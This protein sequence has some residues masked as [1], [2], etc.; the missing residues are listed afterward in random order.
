MPVP[1]TVPMPV[2]QP[3]ILVIIG[4]PLYG[5]TRQL[6]S[7]S[8]NRIGGPA[9]VIGLGRNGVSMYDKRTV[10]M[11]SYTGTNWIGYERL[12]L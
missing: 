8:D 4:L 10:S 3:H 5:R 9:I 11:Y 6:K 2:V 1:V 12:S 7:P